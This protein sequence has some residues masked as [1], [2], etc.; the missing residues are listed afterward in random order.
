MAISDRSLSTSTTFIN[1]PNQE[2]TTDFAGIQVAIGDWQEFL[3]DARRALEILENI[4]SSQSAEQPE[5]GIYASSSIPTHEDFKIDDKLAKTKTTIE[6]L[7][8]S[9]RGQSSDTI[10]K[11]EAQLIKY[12]DNLAME[13]TAV[14]KNGDVTSLRRGIELLSNAIKIYPHRG[15]YFGNRAICYF[16]MEHFE[17]SLLDAEAAL[18]FEPNNLKFLNRKAQALLKLNKKEEA[19]EVAQQMVGIDATNEA[20]H[21]ILKEF[22]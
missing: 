15:G 10:A 7:K 9:Q 1:M 16:K 11:D 3:T 8:E 19:L 12:V 5:S 6:K 18:S 13:G 2:G 14:A 4:N 22:K 20:G 17:N 21:K